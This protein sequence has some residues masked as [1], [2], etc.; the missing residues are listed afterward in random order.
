MQE[1]AQYMYM[2]SFG[3]S[4]LQQSRMVCIRAGLIENLLSMTDGPGPQLAL[5]FCGHHLDSNSL[6]K[7]SYVL[8][9]VLTMVTNLERIIIFKAD[10]EV[11]M[12]L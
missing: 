5:W 2:S 12:G 4:L 3:S 9:L 8:G 1:C 11:T 10:L 6:S 7:D